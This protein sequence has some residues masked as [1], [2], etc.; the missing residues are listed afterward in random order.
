M[1]S[2]LSLFTSRVLSYTGEKTSSPA[3]VSLSQAHISPRSFQS[4][5]R[6]GSPMDGTYP[7]LKSFMRKVH[8][9]KKVAFGNREREFCHQGEGGGD[10]GG[11][12]EC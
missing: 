5:P 11:R 3:G 12:E 8:I 6:L 1:S 2:V 10:G 4:V 7:N 9:L